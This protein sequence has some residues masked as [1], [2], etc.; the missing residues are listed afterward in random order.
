MTNVFSIARGIAAVLCL[1]PGALANAAS[2]QN[3][4]WKADWDRTVATAKKEG[5]LTISA[6]AGTLWR[7]QLLTFNKDYPEIK[8]EITPGAGRDFWPRIVKEREAGQFLWDLRVGGAETLAYRLKAQGQ[9]RPVR[10][11]LV[12][13]EITD[14]SNW[15]GGFNLLFLDKEKTY[16][17]AFAI[18]DSQS[19]FYN[20]KFISADQVPTAKTLTDPK[21]I[22]K[23][24]IADPR[25]GSGLNTLSVMTKLYGEPYV[26]KL[27]IDQKPLVTQDSRQQLNWLSTGRYPIAIG[28]PNATFVEYESKGGSID[29]FKKVPGLN[30]W[31]PGV[32]A[33]QVLSQNPHPNATKVF[34]N[35]LLSRE[36]QARIIK[37]VQL[38]SQRKDVPL[39]APE[40]AMDLA[41]ISEYTGTQDEEIDP[42]TTRTSEILREI[43]K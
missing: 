11:L 37:A 28:L 16:F 20:S 27:M 17:P 41:R 30:L 6:P 5:A 2:A 24:S 7:D 21:W 26:R 43:L 34:V 23:I 14:E 10:P 4:D 12:L 22:G 32:G 38:N 13:P 9:L 3:S 18:Y 36:V 39:G 35:W 33:L 29:E 31:A 25:G 8:L 1:L 19:I 15:I 42:F 40:I